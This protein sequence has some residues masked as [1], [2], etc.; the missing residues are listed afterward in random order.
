MAACLCG[1]GEPVAIA[2]RAL[3]HLGVAKGEPLRYAKG[4][5]VRGPAMAARIRAG[6][7]DTTQA[8]ACWPWTGE[9]GRRGYGLIRVK[10]RARMAHRVAWEIHHKR[11]VPTGLFVC[12]HCDNPPCVNPAHLFAGTAADNMADAVA[13]GRQAKGDRV[14][15]SPPRGDQSFSRLHPER[16]ARGERVW[17]AK[18][19]EGKVRAIRA[20]VSAGASRSSV[21]ARYGVH[22]DTVRDVVSRKNW[23]HVA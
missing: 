5:S 23:R 3:R 6:V 10:G 18:L 1:C 4:H 11:P 2:D 19:N 14:K 20:E 8:D 15:S 17:I 9:K 16:V 22:R 12:H 21:A 7:A 13:K